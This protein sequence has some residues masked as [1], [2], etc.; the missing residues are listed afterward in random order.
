MYMR[1]VPRMA[2]VACTT[3]GTIPEAPENEMEQVPSSL[4]PFAN[5][6]NKALDRAIR[7]SPAL[8]R[9]CPP[10]TLHVPCCVLVLRTLQR[11]H[12]RLLRP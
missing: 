6:E 9:M 2:R 4:P 10:P 3:G 11:L 7:V 8:S 12:H 5:E 1:H